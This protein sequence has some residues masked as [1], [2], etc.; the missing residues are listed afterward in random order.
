[1]LR[2][3][4]IV[5][6]WMEDLKKKVRWMEGRH[7]STT[8]YAKPSSPTVKK[9][10]KFC[11]NLTWDWV[12]IAPVSTD[13]VPMQ[14]QPLNATFMSFYGLRKCLF[15]MYGHIQNKDVILNASLIGINLAENLQLLN[16]RRT[17]LPAPAQIELMFILLLG[18]VF[19]I[20]WIYLILPWM[21]GE[22]KI[23]IKIIWNQVKVSLPSFMRRL[24]Y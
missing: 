12:K 11:H 8:W 19:D 18:C 14:D 6:R 16:W 20:R 1:M 3:G 13:D 5:V 7:L 2:G 21:Y 9:H 22:Y 10:H 17:M 23:H 4:W 15:K 24:W